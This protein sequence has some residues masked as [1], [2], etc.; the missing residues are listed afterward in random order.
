[1][2]LKLFL[3]FQLFRKKSVISIIS[4]YWFHWETYVFFKK[5][6]GGATQK[7]QLK[8]NKIKQ[9][10]HKTKQSQ[11]KNNIFKKRMPKKKRKQC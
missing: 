11:T 6:G 10:K 1:M 3:L 2:F 5:R 4:K 8:K 7:K 9:I